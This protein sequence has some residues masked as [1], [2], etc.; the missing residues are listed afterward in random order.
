MA[1]VELIKEKSK[2]FSDVIRQFEQTA[3]DL[4]TNTNA[5]KR[6]VS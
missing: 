1:A 2:L 6:Q 5:A 3:I 4:E